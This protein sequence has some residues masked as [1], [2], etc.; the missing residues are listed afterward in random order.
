[1]NEYLPAWMRW[2]RVLHQWGVSDGV[3]AVLENIGSLSLLAAQVLY[4]S[5]PLLGSVVSVNSLQAMA[6]VLENPA[7]KQAFASF[8]REAPSSGSGA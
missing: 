1:M 3:A 4:L 8:L 7:K 6:E 2:S 5:Q